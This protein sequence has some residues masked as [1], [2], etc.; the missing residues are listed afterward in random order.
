MDIGIRVPNIRAYPLRYGR[1]N[2]QLRP[3]ISASSEIDANGKHLFTIC[4]RFEVGIFAAIRGVPVAKKAAWR[5]GGRK[6]WVNSVLFV[7]SKSL[8]L[9]H[10]PA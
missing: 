1:L 8:N 7:V 4:L 2:V 10:H 5:R 6:G 9:Q 3:F